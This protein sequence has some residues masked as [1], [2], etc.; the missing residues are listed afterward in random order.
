[1]EI[2]LLYNS[3]FFF[4]LQIGLVVTIVLQMENIIA[5]KLESPAISV[6]LLIL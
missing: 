1:M 4:H 2:V 6:A 5:S 3:W